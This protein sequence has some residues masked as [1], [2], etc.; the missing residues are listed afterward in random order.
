MVLLASVPTAVYGVLQHYHLDPLNWASPVD[1][2]HSTAGNAIFI[3]AYLIMVV[4]LTLARL[5]EQLSVVSQRRRRDRIAGS[6][7]PM[8]LLA[9]Y[10][11]LLALQLLTIVYSQSRG[12]FIGL[13]V[14]LAYFFVVY[15]LHRRLRWLTISTAAGLAA[16][17]AFL[18]IL[19][20]PR[21]PLAPLRGSPYV[22]RLGQL[23]D[24]ASGTGHVR[25]LIWQGAAALVASNPWR[26]LVGY[27][28]ETMFLA[29]TPFYVPE[30]AHYE[31]R[32]A[33]PDRSHN[34]TFD[35]LI[36]IGIVGFLAQ[37]ALFLSLFLHC[38]QWLGLATT[39][40][41][42]G[43]FLAVTGIGAVAG[44]VGPYIFDGSLRLAG[45]GVPAGVAAGSLLYLISFALTHL[46]RPPK[47]TRRDDLLL[48]A[49]LAAVMAHFIEVHSGI[50]I[51]A[52]RLSFW[53]YAGLALAIGVPLVPDEAT[54]EMDAAP[55]A[56]ATPEVRP[57]VSGA[58][59][60]VSPIVG[61]LLV[62]L[63]FD[64]YRIGLDLRQH[65]LALALIGG[66]VWVMGALLITAEPSRQGDWVGRLV[67]Y[68]ATTVGVWLLFTTLYRPIVDWNPFVRELNADVVRSL[69]TFRARGISM[70][71]AAVF[72]TVMLNAAVGL[73]RL[74]TSTTAL[75]RGLRRLPLHALLVAGVAVLVVVTNLRNSWAE[76]FT[77]Y[78][79][80]FERRQEWLAAAVA[81]GE[82]RALRPSEDRYATNLG[83]AY[84][85]MGQRASGDERQQAFAKALTSLQDALDISPL[86]TDH[87]RNLAKA[88]RVS[89]LNSTD[90]GQQTQHLEQAD[91]LYRYAVTLSPQNATLWAEWA[92]LY[93]EERQPEQALAVLEQSQQ[94]DR[95]YTTTY[96]LR[97]QAHQAMGDREAALADYN[98]ALAINPRLLKAWS[99]KAVILTQLNRTDEAITATRRTLE[100]AP[101]DLVSYSNLALLY[102]KTGQLALALDAARA[103]LERAQ[104]AQRATF[105][106]LITELEAAVARDTST[107][108]SGTR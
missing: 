9:A 108:G 80:F 38:L 25:V 15:A 21:S 31:T 96:W 27:G 71:Y 61:L 34:E 16:G 77:Q 13:G 44:V 24:I 87:P 47:A 1:R 101:N 29:Y 49:L 100:I 59:I 50:A 58:L 73:L 74:P 70:L 4:P 54:T 107:A 35:A 3:G 64:F 67:A 48:I 6:I 10:T 86:N 14:G 2:V 26:A 12:P 37:L 51:A 85:E 82:A 90:V 60:T 78:G 81:H 62:L 94:V 57:A 52:T 41:Q 102:R 8:L 11:V 18:V 69:G 46:D 99:G 5:I 19:N 92:T 72:V 55:R 63:T 66:S 39:R 91:G 75:T 17:I 30:L 20:I 76:V 33:A 83:R 105:E 79:L 84:M 88:H 23:S 53:L 22:G 103:A 40:A 104:G 56:D 95:R 43:A 36:T 28:P 106:S 7:A 93:L 97:A 45:V 98:Q 68:T 65:G 32:G 89:A 42:R